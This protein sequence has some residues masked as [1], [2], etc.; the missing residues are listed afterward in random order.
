MLVEGY[1]SLLQMMIPFSLL[2]RGRKKAGA[3]P[4]LVQSPCLAVAIQLMEETS[5][6]DQPAAHYHQL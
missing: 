6:L 1:L 5:F 2:G 3:F 4:Y